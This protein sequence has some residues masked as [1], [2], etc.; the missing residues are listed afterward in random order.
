MGVVSVIDATGETYTPGDMPGGEVD[1]AVRYFADT[2]HNKK[3]DAADQRLSDQNGGSDDWG[4]VAPTEVGPYFIVAMNGTGYKNLGQGVD[5]LVKGA[6]YVAKY[7]EVTTLSLEGA[8]P[9]NVVDAAKGTYVEGFTYDAA[10][11][12]VGFVVD[13]KLL[14]A[15]EDY[16]VTYTPGGA[17]APTNAGTYTAHLTGEG[18]YDGSEAD[19]KFTVDKLDLSAAT[20]VTTVFKAGDEISDGL[21]NNAV[22]NG[23]KDLTIGKIAS[24][25]DT[26]NAWKQ[27]RYYGADGKV[28]GVGDEGYTA[29]D[30]TEPAK[31]GY[32]YYAKAKEGD[33]N[34]VGEAY[35]TFNVVGKVVPAASFEYDDVALHDAAKEDDDLEGRVF[36]QSKGEAYDASLFSIAGEKDVD[37]T[38]APSTEEG[39]EV[40]DHTA[41]VEVT[42]P[43]DYSIGGVATANFSVIAGVIDT[44]ELDAV[45]ILN[46][47]NVEFG[48]TVPVP[49][50]GEAVEPSISV[51]CNGTALTEGEDYAV[52]VVNDETGEAVESMVDAGTYT[53]TLAS[54]TY[55]VTEPDS[56]KVQITQRDLGATVDAVEPVIDAQGNPG[57]LHTGS[58]IAVEFAGTYTN[59]SGETVVLTL[60]PSWYQLSGLQFKA[61]GSETFVPATEVLGVGEY[62]VNVTPTPACTNYKWTAGQV[63]FRVVDTAYFTDVAADA[64]YS[65]V[66]YKAATLKYMTGV[67]GT[68]LFMPE[69]PINRA[70]LAQV[71]F[72]MAGQERDIDKT[73]P[74]KFPDVESTAWYAQAIAWASAA[75]VVTGYEATGTF[76][77]FD[78]ATR[79]V[80]A[81]MMFRYAAAQ[82]MDVSQR[83]D[84]SA[85]ADAESVSPWAEEAVE[86]AVAEGVMGVDTEVLNPQGDAQR[87]EVAAMAVRL[88]PV[89]PE[90]AGDIPE[91]AGDIR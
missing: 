54:D 85:Y 59:L 88:Q 10:P 69:N 41:V 23:D 17:T 8:Q 16:T 71:L 57:I 19:V 56:F 7:F 38:V 83:A 6:G 52:T 44:A 63:T 3:F 70:E 78:N 65:D 80:I 74:T 73:Y 20:I 30:T 33:P 77:P 67:A 79:E 31:G 14:K 11:Q 39:N 12:S 35:V 46:G 51:S 40:G 27:V 42:I 4:K 24:S 76:G 49:Y 61:E 50:T 86:W 34:V 22:I 62:K 13:G 26:D 15:G 87:A 32:E 72:N 37:F 55:T 47:S 21:G 58:A 29:I 2:N 84:L 89:A 48:S 9:V 68:K 64:W 53:V 82:G 5:K 81:T 28:Y 90:T 75:G 1:Y 45:V 25:I 91:T 43:S 18:A 36:D 66:V 60:D